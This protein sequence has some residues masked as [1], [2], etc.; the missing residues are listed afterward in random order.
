MFVC[1]TSFS[2]LY[3]HVTSYMK[4][5]WWVVLR[6]PPKIKNEKNNKNND[7]KKHVCVEFCESISFLYCCDQAVEEAWCFLTKESFFYNARWKI[8]IDKATSKN[9]LL[10]AMMTFTSIFSCY[11]V[12][13]SGNH[14]LWAVTCK[15][16]SFLPGDVKCKH[17]YF[18]ILWFTSSGISVKPLMKNAFVYACIQLKYGD[19]SVQRLISNFVVLSSI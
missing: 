7:N 6:W 4:L 18:I 11:A 19:I 12:S 8:L 10:I 17:G 16:S 3:R 14:K 5:N 15:R 9:E 13:C 1:L 2:E